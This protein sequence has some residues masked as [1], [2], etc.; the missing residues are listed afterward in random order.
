MLLQLLAWLRALKAGHNQSGP[1]N[2]AHAPDSASGHGARHDPPGLAEQVRP[3][4]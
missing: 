2:P 4:S 1:A 3:T